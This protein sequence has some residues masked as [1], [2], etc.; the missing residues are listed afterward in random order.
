[1]TWISIAIAAAALIVATCGLTAYVLMRRQ[2]QVLELRI[3]DLA[4]ELDGIVDAPPAPPV[5]AVPNRPI[6]TIEILNPIELASSQVR[7]ASLVGSWK[8][9]AITKMV[10]NEAAKQI[11][12]QLAE[13]GVVAEVLIHAAD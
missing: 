3:A 6:I 11:S 4:A 8:P 12:S 10:Y 2:A 5:P 1:M 13:E 7:A 9:D